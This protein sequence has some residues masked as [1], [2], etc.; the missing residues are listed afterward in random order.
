MTGCV[1]VQLFDMIIAYLI[2][3]DENRSWTPVIF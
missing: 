2:I 1:Y 3:I